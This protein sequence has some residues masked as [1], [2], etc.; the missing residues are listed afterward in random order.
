MEVGVK[1]GLQLQLGNKKSPNCNKEMLMLNKKIQILYF[2]Q[3]V[4][5]RSVE[6]SYIKQS[7][8]VGICNVFKDAESQ[9][10]CLL[11]RTRGDLD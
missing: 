1:R 7:A 2:S 5:G 6:N 4:Y 3:S 11:D 9:E 10:P 8:N